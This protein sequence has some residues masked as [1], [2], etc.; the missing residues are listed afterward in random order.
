MDLFI[1]VSKEL[2]VCNPRLTALHGESLGWMDLNI[3]L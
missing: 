1:K 2:K 3:I